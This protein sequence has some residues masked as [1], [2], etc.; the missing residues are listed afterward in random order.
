MPPKRINATIERWTR[1]VYLRPV[2]VG[3][4]GHKQLAC[5]WSKLVLLFRVYIVSTFATSW[6]AAH[7]ASLSFSISQSLLKLMFIESMMPSNCLSLCRPLLLLP[8]IFPSIR[9][10]SNESAL[11]T[12]W[13]KSW[14]FNW[15]LNASQPDRRCILRILIWAWAF[16]SGRSSHPNQLL[17]FQFSCC[18][19]HHPL[20]HAQPL[21]ITSVRVASIEN[22]PTPRKGSHKRMENSRFGNHNCDLQY[23]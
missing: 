13:P 21:E 22:S 15:N 20:I 14:S 6:I 11:H 18:S 1:W 5:C 4:G 12:R 23:V 9:V 17:F 19:I 7:Q 16:K 2:V 3:C 10:L 8:S